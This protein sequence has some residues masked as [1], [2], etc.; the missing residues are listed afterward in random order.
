MSVIDRSSPVPYYEQLYAH[1]VSRIRAGEYRPGER[2]PGES[3]IH[4]DLGLSRAT[5]RQALELLAA[6]G[7]ARKIARRGYFVTSPEE[8][9]GWLIEGHHGFLEQGIGHSDPGVETTVIAAGSAILPDHVCAAL[10]IPR[11]S[12][13][14][15]L[16]R[17]RRVDGQLALF[18]TNYTPPE[19]APVVADAAGVLAGRSSL[20]EALRDAGYSPGGANRVIHALGAP[21]R[22][23][24]QLDIPTGSPLVRIQSISWTPSGLRYDYYET[25]LRTDVVPLKI[26]IAARRRGTTT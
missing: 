13:G 23:A 9:Q 11:S 2:L 1:L 7:W 24:T 15:V 17:L 3:E 19:V 4:R 22:I 25:W 20:N 5:A 10:E 14:F 26:E 12:P 18:S 8:T 16:E 6:N 21:E